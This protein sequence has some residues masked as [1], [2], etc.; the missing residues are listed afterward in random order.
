[1]CILITVKT[2]DFNTECVTTRHA[3]PYI[4]INHA[5]SYNSEKLRY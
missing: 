2:I 4:K 3:L 1:M 5:I